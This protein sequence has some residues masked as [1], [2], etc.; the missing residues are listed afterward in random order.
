METLGVTTPGKNPPRELV[1]DLDLAVFDDVLDVVLVELLGADR[2]LEVVNHVDVHVVVEVLDAEDLLDLRDA[3]LADCDRALLLVDLVVHVSSKARRDA[4]KLL[5]ELLGLLNCARNDQRGTG[6]IDEDG[7]D[8]V[9]DG[10]VV[11]ALNESLLGGDH[12]VAQVVEAE[13]VVGSVGDVG[14]IGHSTL[15]RGHRVL[16]EPRFEP[17]IAIDL[18][19]PFGVTL[20]QVVVHG[21]QVNAIARQRVEI[22]GER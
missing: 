20:H 5:V 9:D 19:H 6:L 21:D 11:P 7:V 16:D 18:A 3:F 17:E 1:D 22:N 14:G 15:L 10:V 13:L 4:R 12:V 2:L 8:L